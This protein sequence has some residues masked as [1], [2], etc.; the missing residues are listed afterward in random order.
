MAGT[1]DPDGGGGSTKSP[2]ELKSEVSRLFEMIAKEDECKLETVDEAIRALQL[3]ADSKWKTLGKR[4]RVQQGIPE[5]FLCPISKSVMVDP[6]VLENGQT[7][8]RLPIQ[9]WL[10]KGHRRCPLT[11]QFLR[12]TRLTPNLLVRRLIVKCCKEQGI[13]LPNLMED[14]GK[15]A[16]DCDRD[17]FES[18]L[19]R[20]SPSLND[21]KVAAKELRDL[22]NRQASVRAFFGESAGAF[23]K[24][25]NPLSPNKVVDNPD[26]EED[27]T[28]IVLNLSI[29]ERNKELMEDNPFVISFLVG[30]LNSR[31]PRTRSIAAAALSELSILKSN[32]RLI[33][34]AG[35]IGPLINVIGEGNI[36]AIVNASSALYKLLHLA[37]NMKNA[38]QARAPSVILQRIVKRICVDEMMGLLA[39]LSRDLDAVDE[40]INFDAVP[41]LLKVLGEDRP[42]QCKENCV[43]ILDKIC[44][45]DP[46]TVKRIRNDEDACGLLLA[47]S[48]SSTATARAQRKAA[49][50]VKKI[51][52]VASQSD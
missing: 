6:V 5:E 43:A 27:L 3:Y 22:T 15:I 42:G 49:S 38:T 24:L 46:N 52:E 25:L 51:M 20:L 26:L 14:E 41:L 4:P 1:G 31:T 23:Q 7:F 10:N 8:D 29:I 45:Y 30:S 17:Y 9:D 33:G 34:E 36:V 39:L 47:L 28:A 40:L 21:Q 37:E 18:L 13:K 19:D 50:I 32:W 16:G 12:D 44:S 48:A 11:L 35:T 2:Q